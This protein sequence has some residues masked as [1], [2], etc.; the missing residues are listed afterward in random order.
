MKVFGTGSV[1]EISLD[2]DVCASGGSY[3]RFFSITE[4]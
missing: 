3:L 2:P 4:P 1:V